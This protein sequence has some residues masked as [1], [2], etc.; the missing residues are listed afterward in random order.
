VLRNIF[1]RKPQGSLPDFMII[2]APKCGTTSLFEYLCCHPNLARP[3]RKEIHYFDEN[4]ERGLAW[5]RRHFPIVEQPQMT[6]EATTAYLFAKN[7]PA[8]AA[9]LVP[10]AKIIAVLR[11]PVRRVI[12]HYW[13]NQRHGRVRGDFES[14]FREALSPNQERETNQARQ[15]IHYP[16]QWGFYKE[17][18]ER[19]FD[20]FPREQFLFIRFEDLA[21]DGAAQTRKVFDF[22]GLPEAV[23]DT[24]TVFN[25]SPSYP[26]EASDITRRLA[27]VY[28]KKNAGL[29][30]LIGAQFIWEPVPSTTPREGNAGAG[31]LRPTA[32]HV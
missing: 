18:I 24:G 2:G 20:H 17:Q 29:D 23:I 13:H 12:S 14:Y 15:F 4:F 30:R 22:L 9:A 19:W 25:A 8:R 31:I 6:G 7:A 26:V 11:D 32:V 3:T 28:R 5:Y 27:E 1:A 21:S 16:V 10:N